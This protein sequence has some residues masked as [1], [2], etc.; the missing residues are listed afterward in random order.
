MSGGDNLAVPHC[1]IW[2]CFSQA[3]LG[4]VLTGAPSAQVGGAVAG[5]EFSTDTATRAAEKGKALP[6]IKRCQK[7]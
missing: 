5:K 4:D 7:Q 6:G 1:W 3:S 2:C